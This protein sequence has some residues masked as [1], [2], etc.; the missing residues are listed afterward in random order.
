M[1]HSDDVHGNPGVAAYFPE[2]GVAR[3]RAG[4][5]SSSDLATSVALHQTADGVA[6]VRATGDVAAL[7]GLLE[8]GAVDLY[9][10]RSRHLLRHRVTWPL[11]TPTPGLGSIYRIRR[12][13]GLDAAGFHHHWE[14]SHGPLAL[15]R[16]QGMWDYEQLSVVATL[17]GEPVDGIAVVQWPT[18]EDLRDRFVDGPEGGAA[19]RADA[20]QMADLDYLSSAAM[21]E[22]IHREPA[23]PATG[24]VAVTDFRQ[25]AFDVPVATVWARL[26]DFGELLDWWPGDHV[27]CDHDP[28]AGTRRLTRADGSHVLERLCHHRPDEHMFELEILEGLPASVPEYTCRYE[29]RS[30]GTGTCRLDWQP[31]AVVDATATEVFAEIVDHGWKLIQAGL[32]DL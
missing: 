28:V 16:H 2:V 15:A 9:E 29:I 7:A 26:S 30:T 14:H 8:S 4:S 6:M 10:T 17:A 3:E 22:I 18:P 12:R 32:K 19:I 24:S 25:L 20:A 5:A 13:P 21:T 1:L 27:G 31:Q 23:L 11:G